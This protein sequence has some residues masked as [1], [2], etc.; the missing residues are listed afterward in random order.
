MCFVRGHSLTV[1][2]VFPIMTGILNVHVSASLLW[3]DWE[4]ISVTNISWIPPVV[5]CFAH[6]SLFTDT[7]TRLYC[8]I[9]YNQEMC[10][11]LR[12]SFP[13]SSLTPPYRP[14]FCS[15]KGWVTISPMSS[16]LILLACGQASLLTQTF[17]SVSCYSGWCTVLGFV[18]YCIIH[19]FWSHM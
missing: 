14:V 8:K 16:S 7:S 12:F 19:T 3:K 10:Q 18:V 9:P 6:Y 17:L 1:V 13:A 15:L 11:Y 5:A 4:L 2:K